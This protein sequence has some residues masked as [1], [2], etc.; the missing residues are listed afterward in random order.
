[1]NLF[2]VQ[3]VPIFGETTDRPLK[4]TYGLLHARDFMH[5]DGPLDHPASRVGVEVEIMATKG[6]APKLIRRR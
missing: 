1:M 2:L 4:T 6:I 5:D 3:R